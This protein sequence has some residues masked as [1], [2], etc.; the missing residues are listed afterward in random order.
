MRERAT[1]L[2]G[3]LAVKSGSREGT[4]ID[5]RIPMKTRRKGWLPSRTRSR[6]ANP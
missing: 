6:C 1:F 2:G 5:V 4:E 3:T